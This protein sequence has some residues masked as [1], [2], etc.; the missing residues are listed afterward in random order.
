MKETHRQTHA[1]KREQ[2][3]HTTQGEKKNRE[4]NAWIIYIINLIIIQMFAIW[5]KPNLYIKLIVAAACIKNN[6]YVSFVS[7]KSS[8]QDT[9]SCQMD[10]MAT[11]CHQMSP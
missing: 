11:M 5:Q 2:Q 10:Q 6:V 7:E 8:K 9:C 1:H 3:E 4:I